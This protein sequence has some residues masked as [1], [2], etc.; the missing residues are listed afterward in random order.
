M[1]VNV[2]SLRYGFVGSEGFHKKPVITSGTV[3][4]AEVACFLAG[5]F[6]EDL[7]FGLV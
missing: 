1:I 3:G 6:F 7:D 2:V 4:E 5:F